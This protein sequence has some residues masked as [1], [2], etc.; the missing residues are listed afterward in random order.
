MGNLL[1][2]LLNST[3]ALSVYDRAFSVIQNNIAN[4]NTPGYV[5]QNQSLVAAPLDLT[6]GVGG[7]VI[8]GPVLSSRSEYLEQDV[9]NQ[10]SF[11]G[12]AQQRASDLAQVEPLFDITG[13]SG[14]PGQLNAFFNSFSQLSVNPN[15]DSGRQSVLAA[16]QSLAQSINQNAAGI[17]QAMNNVDGQIPGVVDEINRLAQQIT[18]LNTQ[19]GQGVGASQDAGLD[20]QMHTALENLSSLVN[21]TVLKNPDGAVNIYID[22]QTPLVI[23][24]HQ[25]AISP[26]FSSPQTVIR[27]AQ[28]NDITKQIAGG[29][30]GALLQEKNS[31]LPGYMADLNTFAQNL[32]DQ[33]NQQLAQGLDKSGNPPVV[34]LF[35]YRAASPASSL[36]VTGITPDQIAAAASGAPGGNG[37]ALAIAQMAETGSING[38]SFTQF[39][40]NL[41]ARVGRDVSRANADQSQAQDLVSQAQQIRQQETGVNLDAEAA[42]LLQFQQAYQA[43]AK[44]V[45]VMNDLTQTVINM[46]PQS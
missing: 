20:A 21:F 10:Q 19:F 9:R 40:G 3:G 14:V 18:S 45:T 16:A 33:V 7:G 26:D 39:Y 41:G 5:D 46:I 11:L 24:Q 37:N 32:A 6:G 34:N 35:S 13:D 28:G 1:T 4:V 27:D 38:V 17:T 30:L 2:S 15:S 44:V 31:I 29:S 22:A 43:V 25:Y 23:N 36:A 8:A 12:N 42:K